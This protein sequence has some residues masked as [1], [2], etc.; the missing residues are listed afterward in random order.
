[1][2]ARRADDHG[3]S[4]LAVFIDSE[5]KRRRWSTERAAK[6]ADRQHL[7]LSG[8]TVRKARNDLYREPLPTATIEALAAAFHVT[9]QRIQQLDQERWS[10][11]P[12]AETA[13][14]YDVVRGIERDSKL[15]EH[16]KRIL[17]ELYEE[18]RQDAAAPDPPA[19]P[20]GPGRR[21]RRRA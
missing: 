21:N 9:P 17:I 10:L 12:K 15:P 20:K 4:P 19:S 13:D 14:E 7:S 11:G 1:M 16:K 5:L 3:M 6:E 8:E 2:S 18:F